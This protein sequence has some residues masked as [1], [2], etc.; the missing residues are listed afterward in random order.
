[1]SIRQRINP[2]IMIFFIGLVGCSA[3]KSQR[4]LPE[5][6]RDMVEIYWEHALQSDFSAHTLKTLTQ[7]GLVDKYRAVAQCH[8]PPSN[9]PLVPQ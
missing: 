6:S 7:Q 3:S 9:R 1:M 2:L 4:V 5:S 8:L